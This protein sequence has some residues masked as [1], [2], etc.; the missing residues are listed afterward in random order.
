MPKRIWFVQIPLL[1]LLLYK[2]ISERVRH[3]KFGIHINSLNS[4]IHTS[5]LF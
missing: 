4:A 5:P 3:G 2:N 1:T